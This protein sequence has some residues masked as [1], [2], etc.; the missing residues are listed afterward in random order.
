MAVEIRE[1][2]IGGN[3][4]EF[5]EVVDYIYRDDPHYVRPVDMDLKGRLS[6]KNPFFEHGEATTFTAHR[7]GWCV[8][9]C[10]AS[11]DRGHLERY[12]D[13]CGFFGFL[14]TVDDDEV[15]AELLAAATSWL[16]ARGMRR[17]RGPLSLCI[18]E[19]PGCLV[20]GFDTPPMIL[21]PHHLPHQ[22]PLIERAGFEKVKDLLAWRYVVGDVPK[23]AQKARAS[24]KDLS[25]VRIRN[26]EMR[27]FEEELQTIMGVFN[28]A[29][30]DNWG[31]VPLTASELR[32]TAKE[33]RPIVV[34][35]LAFIA[36]VEGQPAAVAMS[37]PNINEAIADLGGKLLPFGLAK[38]LW[39]VKVRGPKTARL[40]I[41]GIRKNLR[42]VR[43]Y[44]ALS[45]ALY[46]E[47]NDAAK[48]LGIESGELSWTLE[49]NAPVNTGIKMMGGKVYKKYRLY[50]KAIQ[51]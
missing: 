42:H 29:W 9:R 1:T 17:V 47:M 23:R 45:I 20:E 3:L 19:E 14:D 32:H 40:F 11:I 34:P 31:F 50:E 2:P 12:R 6:K 27:R 43:K 51:A 39:R 10:S 36:E 4:R 48:R 24:V 22:G 33:L 38:L 26:V 44:A 25:E 46:A 49:D 13:D 18:N 21:M 37:L 28:D 16:A 41:L 35:Q 30:S 5:L 8:G 15:A 7:N